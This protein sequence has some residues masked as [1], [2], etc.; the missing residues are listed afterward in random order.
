MI[1]KIASFEDLIKEYVS[2]AFPIFRG[3]ERR[4]NRYFRTTRSVHFDPP[5]AKKLVVWK[6]RQLNESVVGALEIY[7]IFDYL[8]TRQMPFKLFQKGKVNFRSVSVNSS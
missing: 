1:E 2:F 4:S 5:H 3:A 7:S 6:D 8:G